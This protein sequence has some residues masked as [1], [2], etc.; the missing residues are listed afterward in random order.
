VTVLQ[1]SYEKTAEF[2]I[3][4]I[5]WLVTHVPNLM[6]QHKWFD[7]ERNLQVGDVVLFTK[8]DSVVCSAYTYGII[9]SVEYGKDGN[10][11]KVRVKYQNANEKVA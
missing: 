11:R 4:N 6:K 3:L 2:S 5:S 1:R 7:G 8:I 9:T 10:V